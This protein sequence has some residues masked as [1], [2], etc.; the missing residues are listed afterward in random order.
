MK[1][2]ATTKV[3]VLSDVH[4]PY[5]DDKA[6]AVAEAFKKDFKPDITLALGDWVDAKCIATFASDIHD[7]DQFHEFEVANELL[8]RFQ[9]DIF[10]EGNHEERFRRPGCVPQLYRRMMAPQHWLQLKKRGIRWIPYSKNPRHLY[11]LGKLTFIHGFSAAQNACKNEAL[12]F[13]CVVHGHTHRIATVQ[14][15]HAS[16]AHTAF[17]IGCLC[18]LHPPYM[19]NRVG[20]L[21]WAHGFGF[22]YI[23]KSGN[24]TFNTARLIGDYIHL[25]GKQYKL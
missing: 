24:F 13:G 6:L 2:K 11:R 1:V 5:Q 14:V 23:Y 12:A 20:G 9:P 7:L 4:A 18:D 16:A 25:E 15:P 17:N 22:G 21:S 8:D 3:M 10:F 19:E